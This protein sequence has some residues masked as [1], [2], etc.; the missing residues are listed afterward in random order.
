LPSFGRV[1]VEAASD[2]LLVLQDIRLPRGEWH[3]G[4]IDF[5][6]AFGAPGTPVAVDGRLLAASSDAS[7]RLEEPGEPVHVEPAV[8]RNPPV[9]IVVGRPQMAGITLRVKESQLRRVYGTSDLAV[10]RLR[11][12]LRPPAEDDEG[13]RDVVVRLGAAEGLPMTLDQIQVASVE[14][15]PAVVRAEAHL[16][17][18]DADP[19]PLSVEL[20]PAPIL[21]ARGAPTVAPSLASRHASDDLCIR[22]WTRR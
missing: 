7:V 13:A 18:S 11:S 1:R 5:Y 19:L 22:W 4:D 8:R 15:G 3:S 21:R 9:D 14:P 17:G 2:H 12:L 16:C 6:V 10:L 20:V